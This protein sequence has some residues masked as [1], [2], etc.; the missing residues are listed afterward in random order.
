MNTKG[1]G[2]A[3][4]GI[5][6]EL[7][8]LKAHAGLPMDTGEEDSYEEEPQETKQVGRGRKKKTVPTLGK[9]NFEEE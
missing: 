8:N 2:H 6:K 4:A 3:I 5:E 7:E 1:I 9:T